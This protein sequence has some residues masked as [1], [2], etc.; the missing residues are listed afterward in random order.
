MKLAR[1]VSLMLDKLI[2]PIAPDQ[3][4]S[5]LSAIRSEVLSDSE[6]KVIP[7]RKSKYFAAVVDMRN[8]D[9][10]DRLYSI[11]ARGGNHHDRIELLHTGEKRWTEIADLL[12]QSVKPSVNHESLPVRRADCCA[13]LR[14]SVDYLARSVRCQYKRWRSEVGEIEFYDNYEDSERGRN[15]VQFFEIGRRHLETLYLGRF[16]NPLRVYDKTAETKYRY[17]REERAHYRWLM[18]QPE[19]SR[20]RAEFYRSRGIAQKEMQ[21]ERSLPLSLRKEARD[22]CKG[23]WPFVSF[24]EWE[25]NKL[26]LWDFSVATRIERQMSGEVPV[27][28]STVKGLRDNAMS[29]NP[30][31]RIQFAIPAGGVDWSQATGLRPEQQLCGERIEQ[32][33]RDEGVTYDELYRRFG[34]SRT[35]KRTGRAVKVLQKYLH[36]IERALAVDGDVAITADELYETY[37]SSIRTQFQIAA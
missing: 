36:F 18:Q 23:L 7:F 35:G 14:V 5:Q 32:M 30:F 21:L 4:S 31:Q 17:S 33:V 13:D 37:R 27:L 12:H 15:R 34:V 1:Y 24:R 25:G 29:F 22:V 11:Q 10:T 20:V 8:V 3:V 26:K 6:C 2:T 16:P 9:G 19:A 28:I